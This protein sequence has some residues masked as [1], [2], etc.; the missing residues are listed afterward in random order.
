MLDESKRGWHLEGWSSTGCSQEAGATFV[1]R[2]FN[3]YLGDRRIE[4]GQ[5]CHW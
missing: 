4:V 3:F 5:G 2:Y 1:I